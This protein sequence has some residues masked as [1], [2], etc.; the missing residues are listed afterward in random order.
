MIECGTGLDK[1]ELL[2]IAECFDDDAL[3]NRIKFRP[4]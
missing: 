1:P 3:E 2:L 4:A